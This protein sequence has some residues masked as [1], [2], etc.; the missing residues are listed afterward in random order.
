M[1]AGMSL[2]KLIVLLTLTA[3]SLHFARN[4]FVIMYHN[5]RSIGLDCEG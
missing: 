3:T 1:R 2:Q 4:G 5:Y